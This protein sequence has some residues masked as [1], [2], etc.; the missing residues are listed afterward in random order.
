MNNC[1][2]L[3]ANHAAPA[4]TLSPRASFFL[5]A[6]ITVS[7]LAGSLAPTPLYPVY[8]AEWGFSA[9]TTTEI[10][11]IYALALLGSLLVAGRLSDHVGRRPVLI[12]ATLVQA[13]VMLMFAT[14]NGVAALMLGRVVQGLATGAA[15]GAVGA[16]MLDLDK[17]RGPIA[18]AVTPPLGTGAG[19]LLAG[20]L[21]HY[22]PAPT[23]LVYFVLATVFVLQALGVIFMAE[24]VT[25]RAGAVASLKPRFGLPAAARAPMLIAAPVLIA[26]WS[27]AGFYASL[28]PA[29]TRSVFG[30]DPSLASG[31]AA[32]AF[33]GSGAATV[34]ALGSR[35]PRTVMAYGA[36]ALIAG[37][38]AAMGALGAQSAT[39]FFLATAVAGSGFG[40]GFQGAVRTV[41]PTAKAH[42][43]AG[44][45]SVVFVV[46]YL[47][48]GVPAI[49]AGFLVSRGAQLLATAQEFGAV[50]AILSALALAGTLSGRRATFK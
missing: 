31:I 4:R 26:A 43:R 48:M 29:L 14:A 38:A 10:F 2:A 49:I 9:L 13:V 46:S 28:I 39:G 12:V 17:A 1:T 41:L 33:A 37:T 6:S 45:L 24:T 18:N 7:F 40:A 35:A 22:L 20:L 30:F 11:G 16:G 47:A 42:E 5:V 8:Q 15:L 3:T 23:L 34:L 44:V 19:G 36:F 25:R 32:F 27:L 50:V 21:V